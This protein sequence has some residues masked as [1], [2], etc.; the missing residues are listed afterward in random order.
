MPILPKNIQSWARL[1]ASYK[2]NE[3]EN[4]EFESGSNFKYESALRL[5]VLHNINVTI[6][7]RN[8]TRWIKNPDIFSPKLQNEAREAI[9][10]PHFA[11]L[12]EVVGRAAVGRLDGEWSADDFV[13][14]R[15]FGPFLS[16]LGLI[17]HDDTG[18]DT[19]GSAVTYYNHTPVSARTRSHQDQ[20]E[21]PTKG[22]TR[23]N[24]DVTSLF[25]NLEVE[26]TPGSSKTP[27]EP[28]SGQGSVAKFEQAKANVRDEQTVN[29]CLINLMSPITWPLDISGN[30]DPH[31]RAFKF[32]LDDLKGYQACVDGIVTNSTRPTD[33]IGILEVKKGRRTHEVRVQEA[34]EMVAFMRKSSAEQDSNDSVV[35]R[36]I[37][38]AHVCFTLLIQSPVD[39][40]SLCVPTKCSSQLRHAKGHIMTSYQQS[41]SRCKKCLS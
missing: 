18:E 41:G 20:Y 33:V 37:A 32:P 29:Q 16:L 17:E 5:R 22:T 9:R 36:Y 7:R 14:A 25:K 35:K 12:L 10:G 11:G 15:C 2:V 26:D 30:I 8:E 4:A 34:A 28:P 31:R 19:G 39:G 1:Y 38:S 24:Q 27:E 6:I 3:L 13:E 40:W 23:S 21:T